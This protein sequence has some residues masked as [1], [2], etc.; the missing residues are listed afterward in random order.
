MISR[1]GE[2][3]LST[4]FRLPVRLALALSVP[5]GAAFIGAPP[6][7][8]ADAAG[9]G[10]VDAYQEAYG[11]PGLA[12]AVIDGD[13]VETAVRGNDGDGDAVTPETLFR[14]ASMSKS[15]TAASIMILV[16]R[17]EI[18][19]D[20][21]V[22]DALPEFT[23]DD[24][25][26]RDMTVRHL[27]SHTSGLS[28]RT[29]NE[30]ALPPPGS[31]AEAVAG[32]AD[33]A[34]GAAPGAQYEYH[35]TNYSVAAR[36][37]EFHSGKP[38]GEFL[39]TELFGPLG[40]DR[41]T[42]A[43]GCS[44]PVAGLAP[45]YGTVLGLSLPVPEMPGLCAGNGGVVSS[46]DDMVRWVRFNQGALG[47]GPLSADSLKE[48]H[49]AQPGA[50]GHGLGWE[51]RPGPEEGARPLIG[52]DGA[53]ATWTGDMSFSPGTGEAA[54]VLAN[55][56]GAP[57]LLSTALLA[58]RNGAEADPMS[59]P[60][61]TVNAVLLGLTLLAGALL[62]R[63]AVRARRW[64]VRHREARRPEVVLRLV[65]LALVTAAGALLPTLIG[66]AGGSF[67]FHYWV[68]TAWLMP[69]LALF[70]LVC[71]TLGATA[72]VRRVL[73]RRRA[74]TRTG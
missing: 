26:F 35:N 36:I 7:A 50:D 21:P 47:A 69:L 14:I 38:F 58:E 49:T 62:A 46:L 3:T 39:E 40:M 12:V 24:P 8:H 19:L 61:T 25:R 17:G 18:G 48:M 20:D 63:T 52:H 22:A 37:V 5:V 70:S 72:L 41:T 64:A 74:R 33:K 67:S 9:G 30:Y 71:L 4:R 56:A 60:L 2:R 27:L 51:V 28:I 13:S 59:N 66:A 11:N 32:L 29:N 68:V 42:A 23:M 57:R 15:M 1:N 55:G 43:E 34:L 44:D 45:G 10:T 16:E 54:I 31:A 6:P 53:L 73:C 65:P